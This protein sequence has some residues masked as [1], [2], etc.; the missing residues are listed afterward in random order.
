MFSQHTWSCQRLVCHEKS[1]E[2]RLVTRKC[3]HGKPGCATNVVAADHA[4]DNK[5]Q[6]MFS[7]DKSDEIRLVASKCNKC[8][9]SRPLL[10]FEPLFSQILMGK[11]FTKEGAFFALKPSIPVVIFLTPLLAIV[12]FEFVDFF[13]IFFEFFL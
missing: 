13:L 7:Q 11:Y 9:H 6:Q 12:C 10:R 2:I 8:C 3:C 4:R 5:C 1:D